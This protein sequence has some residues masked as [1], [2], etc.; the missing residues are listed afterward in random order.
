[1]KVSAKLIK[2][3]GLASK[4]RCLNRC[5]SGAFPDCRVQG[6][7]NNVAV[8]KLSRLRSQP[9][10]NLVSLSKYRFVD[11]NSWKRAS[12]LKEFSCAAVFFRAGRVS[13]EVVSRESGSVNGLHCQYI[14]GKSKDYELHE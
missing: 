5:Y 7:R 14:N 8:F 3:N 12:Y 1:M 13:F 10:C 6:S 4:K 11:S 2:H 9:T